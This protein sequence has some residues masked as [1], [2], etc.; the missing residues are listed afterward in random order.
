MSH[1]KNSR[2]VLV[3]LFIAIVL[4]FTASVTV[5]AELRS[6]VLFTINETRNMAISVSYSSEVPVISFIGPDGEK[7]YDG[8]PDNKIS[9]EYTEGVIYYMISNAMPGDWTI[10]Y[11]KLSNPTLEI[12]YAPYAE[13]V[14]IERFIVESIEN[15]AANISFDVSYIDNSDFEYI[16]SAAITNENNTVTGQKELLK[17]SGSSNTTT[18]VKVPLS[19]L[20]SYDRYHFK[21]E[22]Y[23]DSGGLETFDTAVTEES[24]SYDNYR[25]TNAIKDFYTEINLT[26]KSLL[27]DWS[28]ESVYNCQEYIVSV[29]SSADLDEPMFYSAYEPDTKSTEVLIDPSVEFIRVELYYRKNDIL[30]NATVKEINFN[31]GTSI[32]I[33]TPEETNAAQAVINYESAGSMPVVVSV[34][35]N[36]ETINISGKGYFSVEIEE[37]T[38][39]IQ[40]SYS[41][42]QNVCFVVQAEI[43]SDRTPPLLLLYEN[44]STITTT[45][46]SYALTGETEPGCTLMINDQAFPVNEDGTFLHDLKLSAGDNMF[47]V[48][49]TD[50]AGN[51]AMQTINIR[52]S[53][54]MPKGKSNLNMK[55][56]LPLII[57]FGLS[58][59]LII[60]VLLFSKTYAKKV[61]EGKFKAVISAIRNVFAVTTPIAFGI[62]ILMLFLRRSASEII[63]SAEYYNLVQE[64]VRE[65]YEAINTYER[66]NN[67]FI[68]SLIIFGTSLLITIL[69]SWAIKSF[70]KNKM[71]NSVEPGK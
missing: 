17:G 15:E 60:C 4:L 13:I 62:S 57:T 10:E 45:G 27:V 14:R 9:V 65:A 70:N 69:L 39:E 33:S 28:S 58:M 49:A 61:P 50:I 63:N 25:K 64:S 7:Y 2:K 6:K 16:V 35:G 66:I 21:L 43:Y 1:I 67:I 8:V 48:I 47:T 3:L 20:S 31:T 71:K 37:F 51:S 34:N 29:Y 30:S 56:F 19:S 52:K 53:G 41:P 24:F 32:S 22:V 54:S 59:L 40:V 44:T 23:L 55:N 68:I 5:S 38:N 12:T 46:S 36:T 26:K 42:E 11:D 18:S